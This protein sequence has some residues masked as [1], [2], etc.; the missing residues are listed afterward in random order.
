MILGCET[1]RIF[2][3]PLREL[4]PETSHGFACIAFAEDVLEIK[5][6]PWQKWLL[7]HALELNEDGLYR[8]RTVVCE[9]ARQNGKSLLMIILALWHLYGLGSRTVIGTAQ[10][11]TRS[12]KSWA[13]AV[14]W[15][16][17]NDELAPYV[18]DVKRGHP[19]VLEILF[20][21]DAAKWRCEYRVSAASRRGGRGFTG[22]LILMDELR[23]HQAWDS[24]A[25]VA[26][27]MNARPKAQAWAF[28]NAGDSLS[29]VLRYLRACAHRDLGWP[30]G[31]E[32]AEVLGEVEDGL[33][34]EPGDAALGWF[35]WSANPN[36]TRTDKQAWAQANPSINHTEVTEN[37]ITERAITAALRTSPPHVFDMECMCRWVSLADGGPFTEGSWLATLDDN[38]RPA[39]RARSA[40]CVEVSDTTRKRERTY[41]ARAALDEAGEPVFGIWADQMGSDWV[42]SWLL[43]HRSEYSV[44]VLRSGA[45]TP[46][47]SLLDQIETHNTEHPVAELPVEKWGAADVSAAHGQMFDL[48]RDS[49]ARH[50]SHPGMDMAATSAA[51]KLQAGG[52]WVLDSIK[53]PT[54]TAP[55]MAALGAVWGLGHLPDDRPSIYSGAEGAEVLV[56]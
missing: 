45:G 10:D 29:V 11:L 49:Q 20:E 17:E 51:I 26:N 21:D 54:D 34:F 23:E 46:A 9:V 6:F 43:E 56:L 42:L 32:D 3:P 15:A 4:T 52:G 13:D 41:I 14:E 39:D 38:A 37:C 24:W 7:V 27:T 12:E 35:E 8:F 18:V 55:L 47:L 16:Q 22:D 19:K 31:D 48:L 44:I 50:L 28:S 36:A 33:E 53:S 2:T 5:L 30:D 25:A 40:V 1:P